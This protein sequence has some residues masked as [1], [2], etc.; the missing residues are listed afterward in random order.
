MRIKWPNSSVARMVLS[1]S[2]LL[3]AGS[4]QAAQHDAEYYELEKQF[5]DQWLKDD[6]E[7]QARLK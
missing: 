6:K 4:S 5:G 1:G 3:L 2:L 7:V